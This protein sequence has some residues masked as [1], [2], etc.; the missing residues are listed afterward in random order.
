[1]KIENR[2]WRFRTIG[3][4]K[5]IITDQS[6]IKA[7]R[8]KL[9]QCELDYNNF[10]ASRG[11]FKVTDL[12][13]DLINE[14]L[15][16]NTGRSN[17]KLFANEK[18]LKILQECKINDFISFLLY[19]EVKLTFPDRFAYYKAS[20]SLTDVEICRVEKLTNAPL[21]LL[22][23]INNGPSYN[24]F[25]SYGYKRLTI[26]NDIFSQLSE[27][28]RT[29]LV[30]VQMLEDIIDPAIDIISRDLILSRVNMNDIQYD[31]AIKELEEA[32]ALKR[33]I[34]IEY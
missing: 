11:T 18:D 33:L 24:F 7:V 16:Y 13:E 14:V 19:L 30:N 4:I 15:Y 23:L 26:N 5:E 34:E 28:A 10:D 6:E 12:N 9:L 2:L 22:P 31:K 29:V 27:D 25:S 20:L 3:Q 21:D 8:V 32:N 17:K 1:M